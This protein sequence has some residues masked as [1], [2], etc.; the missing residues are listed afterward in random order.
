M[1][2]KNFVGKSENLSNFISEFKVGKFTNLYQLTNLYW[3]LLS[4]FISDFPTSL[5]Q[6]QVETICMQLVGG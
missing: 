4:N 1:L 6:V 3:D 2:L 5:C